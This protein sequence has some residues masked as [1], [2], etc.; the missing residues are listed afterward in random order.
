MERHSSDLLVNLSRSSSQG[1]SH[2]AGN[3]CKAGPSGLCQQ[4]GLTG[5]SPNPRPRMS[6]FCHIVPPPL[7]EPDK[8]LTDTKGVKQTIQAVSNTSF[9]MQS[10]FLQPESV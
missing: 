9:D 8:F 1:S 7:Q 5:V 3:Q 4:S 2:N 6:T 10:K